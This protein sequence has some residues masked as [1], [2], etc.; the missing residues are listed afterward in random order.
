MGVP[1]RQHLRV[2]AERRCVHGD[3]GPVR[4]ESV[5]D[6]GVGRAHR[7]ASEFAGAVA[8]TRVFAA[9]R[10]FT[11][12]C[13]LDAPPPAPLSATRRRHRVFSNV[14]VAWRDFKIAAQRHDRNE[15]PPVG[16]SAAWGH[17]S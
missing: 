9:E 5:A 13:L 7:R 17:T 3:P 2:V 4:M 8:G 15:Y 6:G 14:G 10:P 1:P 12:V 16:W 11:Y